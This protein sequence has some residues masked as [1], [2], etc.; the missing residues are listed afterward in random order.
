MAS[1]SPAMME[2]FKPLMSWLEE[3]NKGR[4]IGWE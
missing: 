1:R 2:Y 3:Q 4:Q